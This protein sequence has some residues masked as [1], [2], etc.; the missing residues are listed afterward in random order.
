[1]RTTNIRAMR[2]VAYQDIKNYLDMGWI[3]EEPPIFDRISYYGVTMVWTCDC[4]LPDKR[5]HR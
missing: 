4:A 3:V 1:M 2:Y 5:V